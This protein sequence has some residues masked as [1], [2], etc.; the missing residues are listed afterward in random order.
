MNENRMSVFAALLAA[1]LATGAIAQT[2][3]PPAPAPKPAPTTPAP[4]ASGSVGMDKGAGTGAAASPAK[5]PAAKSSLSRSER[6]FIEKAMQDGMEEV[7]MSKLA[8]DKAQN[9]RVKEFAKRLVDDHSK[10]NAELTRLAG[11]KG[12]TLPAAI[13]AGHQRKMER[14]AKKSGADFDREYMS[15]ML[16]DHQKNVR[17]HQSMAKSAKD[18]DIRKY[19]ATMVPTLEQ[20]L[21]MAKAADAA[22]KSASKKAAKSA[23][24]TTK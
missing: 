3:A 8:S 2:S 16:G 24:A 23:A 9:A 14:M 7:E 21:Q 6:R 13:D 22:V 4:P 17:D 15:D 11:A 20:H 10:S 1:G 18:A 12:V 19:A 5:G